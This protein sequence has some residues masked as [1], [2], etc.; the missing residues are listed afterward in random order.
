MEEYY[1]FDLKITLG[2]DAMKSPADVGKA[3]IEL[4]HQLVANPR[5]AGTVRDDNGN[6]VGEYTFYVK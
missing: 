4:A 6:N 1:Q 5:D 3:L 2:N